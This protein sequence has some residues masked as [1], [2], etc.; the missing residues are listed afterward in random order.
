MNDDRR[1]SGVVKG[2]GVI[3]IDGVN[4][5]FNLTAKVLAK[6]SFISL[7]PSNRKWKTNYLVYCYIR[8]RFIHHVMK[9]SHVEG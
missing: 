3:A 6:Q 8:N 9:N 4:D 1:L 2:V 5:L 7:M